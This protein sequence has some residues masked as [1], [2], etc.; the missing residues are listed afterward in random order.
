MKT[1]DITV[2]PVACLSSI[3]K[4]FELTG[5]RNNGVVLGWN[6]DLTEGPNNIR[7]L[8]YNIIIIFKA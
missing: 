5:V 6:I 7:A 3:S 1:S 4:G 8:S 2:Y